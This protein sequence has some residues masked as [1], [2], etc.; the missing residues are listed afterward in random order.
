MI[1]V[2]VGTVEG[3][4]Q[5]LQTASHLKSRLGGITLCPLRH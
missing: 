3:K 4:Y 2:I 1:K 5:V